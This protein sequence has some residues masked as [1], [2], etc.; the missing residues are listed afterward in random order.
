[1]FMVYCRLGD[2]GGFV[3]LVEKEDVERV[4]FYADILELPDILDFLV[5][6]VF[7]D[8]LDALLSSFFV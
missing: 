8:D 3:D 1:M 2:G 4:V 6:M 7:L 5:S